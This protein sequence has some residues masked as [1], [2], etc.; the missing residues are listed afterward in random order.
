MAEL[1]EADLN[2]SDFD[3][4]TVFKELY[5]I[6][7]PFEQAMAVERM[8]RV[9][10]E[11]KFTNFKA[12]WKMYIK[13][14]RE[15]VGAVIEAQSGLTD[16]GDRDDALDTGEWHADDLGIWKYGPG[17]VPIVACSH[18]IIP[19]AKK[20]SIDSKLL[21][22]SLAYRRGMFGKHNWSYVDIDAADMSSPNEIVKKL[23]PYGIS[24]TGGDRAKA[25]VDFLR[26][27]VDRNYDNMPEIKCVSR[28]GWN[29][30]GFSPYVSD[31]QFDGAQAFSAAY[32]A[33]TQVGTMDAWMA[34]AMDARTKSVTARIV[35]AA[36]F[37]SPLIEPL[38]IL[39]FFVHLWSTASGTGKT[40]GQM[41]GASV[42]GNPV[43]GGPFFPT[44]RS[45]SVGLELMAGFLHSLPFFIDELQLA[46]D[47][48]GQVRFNVYELA[49]GSGKLRGNRS[50]GL[51]YTPTWAMVFITSGE[52]PIT[53]ETDGEGAINRVFEIE[54]YADKKVIDDGHRTANVLKTNYGHAGK[55]FIEKLIEGDG[56]IMDRPNIAWAKEVY[57]QNYAECLLNDTTEKQAMAAAAI[58]TADRLATEWIF[59]DGNALT[60]SDIS[61][62]LKTKERVSM[63]DRAYDILC[64]WVAINS[65]KLRGLKDEDKGECYGI[66]EDR[67]AYIIRSVFS[68]VCEENGLNEVGLL[69]HLRTKRLIDTGKKG[70]TKIHYLGRNFSTQCVCLLLPSEDV[71]D[72]TETGELPF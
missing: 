49:S 4:G 71:A 31:T 52:T 57:E 32:S 38:G 43:P 17:N 47:H 11:M 28:V 40:V 41:L 6:Q 9:A 13:K 45:T 1:R 27:V 67:T 53:K 24:V 68:K 72:G 50:L 39:P 64:D 62:F 61:E 23:S 8:A 25:M 42:W 10:K 7:D 48:H 33:I 46:K 66:V 63:M 35:L 70:F 54:C 12:L 36:S 15:S 26:D 20:R 58:L 14:Q 60:L 5:K 19:V 55:V 29:E 30:D 37:A 3:D 34:E 44:F 69:S 65:N 21:K 2:Y 16:F 18:P 56:D 22:Y 59:Q 51:N